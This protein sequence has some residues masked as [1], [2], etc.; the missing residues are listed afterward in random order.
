[1]AGSAFEL[2]ALVPVQMQFTFYA[3]LLRSANGLFAGLCCGLFIPKDMFLSDRTEFLLISEGIAL[4]GGSVWAEAASGTITWIS[5]EVMLYFKEQARSR[6]H[7]ICHL[8]LLQCAS[9]V[10]FRYRAAQMW[11]LSCA[12]WNGFWVFLD[13]GHVFVCL[14]SWS[15][16]YLYHRNSSSCKL[17]A[18][19]EIEPLF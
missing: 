4:I 2:L 15:L 12:K 6:L 3:R 18:C 1:M 14:V 10:I 16:S 5:K 17:R 9:H 19:L 7:V 8:S 11:L 13:W